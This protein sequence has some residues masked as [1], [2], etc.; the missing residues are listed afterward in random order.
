MKVARNEKRKKLLGFSFYINI[1]NFEAFLRILNLSTNHLFWRCE[2]SGDMKILGHFFLERLL[3]VGHMH[4]SICIL[5]TK[6]KLDRVTE[7]DTHEK[8]SAQRTKNDGGIQ[9]GR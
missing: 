7:L 8:I 1:R 9:I 3:Y 6:P 2:Q 4:T 5:H